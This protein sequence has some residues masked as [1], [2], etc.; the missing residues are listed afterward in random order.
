MTGVEKYPGIGNRLI[1]CDVC[2]F[3][4]R[5]KQTVQITD[6]YN[7]LNKAIVCKKCYEKANPQ[8]YP[9]KLPKEQLLSEPT[10]VRPESEQLIYAPNPLADQLPSA[11][12]NLTAM[13]DP[14]TN[15]IYLTWEGP[16]NTGSSPILGYI[17]TRAEPQFAFQQVI[18][19]NDQSPAAYY[20]DTT[21]DITAEYTYQVAAISELGTGPYSNY[22]FWP[23]QLVES[24][25]T[26]NYLITSDTLETI[27]TGA[28]VAII[29]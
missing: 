1:I 17:V 21:S 26:Y 12:R 6:R 18:N 28:G 10:Y 9:F 15:Y 24:P 3:K 19:A 11:P 25:D 22:A 2:G 16:E 20:L 23:K 5:V 8:L 13:L 14:L 27:T 29:I 4:F 7:T